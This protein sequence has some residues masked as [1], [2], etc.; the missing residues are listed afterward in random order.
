MAR[1]ATSS[2]SDLLQENVLTRPRPKGDQIQALNVGSEE[3]HSIALALTIEGL[4]DEMRTGRPRTVENEAV[5]ELITKITALLD[6]WVA[7]DRKIISRLIL[8]SDSPVV[9]QLLR[10]SA[11]DRFTQ[12]PAPLNLHVTL[13]HGTWGRG[14][15]P[16]KFPTK[17]PRWFEPHSAFASQLREQLINERFSCQIRPFLWSGANSISAR[18]LAAKDLATLIGQDSIEHHHLIIGHSH[19]GNIAL[20]ALSHLQ[21]EAL[22]RTIVVTLAT[23]FL[24]IFPRRIRDL[25]ELYILLT[26]FA[27]PLLLSVLTGA[28]LMYLFIGVLDLSDFRYRNEWWNIRLLNAPLYM[29]FTIWSTVGIWG[30]ALVKFGDFFNEQVVGL[31]VQKFDASSR[32]PAGPCALILRSVDDE[33]NLTFAIG[34]LGNRLVARGLYLT[35]F[36][37]IMCWSAITLYVAAL[38]LAPIF[39]DIDQNKFFAAM[40]ALLV[41]TFCVGPLASI[42]LILASGVMRSVF[43]RE[44]LLGAFRQ[45]VAFNSTPDHSGRI[46]IQTLPSSGGLRH[47]IYNHPD[48]ATTIAGW[49]KTIAPISSKIGVS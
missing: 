23:P 32:I 22:Q 46:T 28:S 35:V 19:G 38:F 31:A 15:F 7:G 16:E 18:D 9:E 47:S 4:Y 11:T 14:F 45:D 10:I 21:H 34:A 49:L 48:C 13:V 29:I 12:M 44:L 24:D 25:E 36:L 42:F 30:V 26:L 40:P 37:V 6:R 39:V 43:G 2:S 20:R 8:F 5:A 3:A 17:R 33:P 27:V 1:V 41:F